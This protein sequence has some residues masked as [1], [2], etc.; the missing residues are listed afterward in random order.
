VLRGAAAPDVARNLLPPIMRAH[1]HRHRLVGLIAGLALAGVIGAGSGA[2]VLLSGAYNTAATRQHFAVT[3]WMLEQGLRFSV[4]QAADAVEPP[5]L[6]D[7]AQLRLGAACFSAHC[8][9]CHGGPGVAP[10]PFALGMLP[11]PT[12][13]A[14]SGRDWSAQELY[15]LVSKGVRMTGMPAWEYRL[16]RESRWATVT[17]LQQLP[18]LSRPAYARLLGAAP[19]AGCGRATTLADVAPETD[20]DPDPRRTVIRQYA[21]HA[22]HSI[23]GVVGPPVEVGPPL[24]HWTSRR[25]VAGVLPNTRE[26]LVRW[27]RD[28]Q[29]VAPGTMMPDLGVSEEHAQE[30]ASFLFSQGPP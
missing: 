3:H 18:R 17:F 23:D 11:A 29:G 7:A 19:A 1:R 4:G 20:S 30:I 21:C 12:S 24:A 13:L 5:P 9:Q 27:I 26:N 15:W 2:M 10:E 28:P 14:Q 8:V 6:G 25:Y 16:S 22:C